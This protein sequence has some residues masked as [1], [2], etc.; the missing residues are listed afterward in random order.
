MLQHGMTAYSSAAK[1]AELFR[2]V[3][4][5]VNMLDPSEKLE[6]DAALITRAQEIAHDAGA[7]PPAGPARSELLAA[8]K[9]EPTTA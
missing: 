2:A 1:D 9:L 3:A 7:P 4:R 6:H 5:P 8:I